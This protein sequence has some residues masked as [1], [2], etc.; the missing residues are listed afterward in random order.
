MYTL[1]EDC[2]S[3]WSTLSI[4]RSRAARF[5]LKNSSW[6]CPH[7][8]LLMLDTQSKWLETLPSVQKCRLQQY[9][10]FLFI[11]R[12]PVPPYWRTHWGSH[13]PTFISC[14]SSQNWAGSHGDCVGQGSACESVK[15]AQP[16]R[17]LR[18]RMCNVYTVQLIT[19]ELHRT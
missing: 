10:S 4:L 14:L 18:A 9:V 13:W 16:L 5:T 11:S 15:R 19:W 3:T 12:F 17:V 8:D 1:Y 6:R 2:R 7:L